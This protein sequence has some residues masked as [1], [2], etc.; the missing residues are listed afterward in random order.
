MS[1][2]GKMKRWFPGNKPQESQEET[3]IAKAVPGKEI[4]DDMKEIN[5]DLKEI[6]NELSELDESFKEIKKGMSRLDRIFDELKDNLTELEEMI[7]DD[8]RQKKEA[9]R[10]KLRDVINTKDENKQI[11]EKK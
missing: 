8:I 7:K 5:G 10:E 3:S 6:G 9:H 4:I 2:F 11:K 1:I